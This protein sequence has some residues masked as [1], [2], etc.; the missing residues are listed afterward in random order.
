MSSFWKDWL[1][2][3]L[4]TLAQAVVGILIVEFGNLDFVWAPVIVAALS[5]LKGFAAKQVGKRDTASLG[6]DVVAGR[7]AGKRARP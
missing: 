1:E 2:R 3:V 7:V 4:W 6:G 5:A